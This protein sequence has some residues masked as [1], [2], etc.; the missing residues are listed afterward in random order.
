MM[1]RSICILHLGVALIAFALP[2]V[3]PAFAADDAEPSSPVDRDKMNK[4]FDDEIELLTALI[5]KSPK[6]VDLY[7]R[8][9]D[10]NFF[11]GKFAEAVADY[12]QMVKLE[13]GLEQQHWR[14]GIAYFYDKRYKDAAKQ[15]EIYHS[16]DNVD[17]ENGIWRYLSQ[18]KAL[19][20][21]KARQGLLKYDK[22]DREPFP[23]VYRLFS[24]EMAGDEVLKRINDAKIT[25]QQRKIRLFYAELYIGL[26]EFVE[27]RLESAEEHLKQAVNND[28]G[29]KA[30]G[31]PGY[32]WHVARV[33]HQLLVDARSKKN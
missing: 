24:G 11:R 33:H 31:G 8:R 3:K 13:P 19:G 7:S 16:F 15:F 29:A 30:E 1:Y 4:R 9:G 26:N 12:E 22:D 27:G 5:G 25:A 18:T 32:M 20:R 23:D 21:E 17:R 28:W 10:A 14:K 6:S 2:A